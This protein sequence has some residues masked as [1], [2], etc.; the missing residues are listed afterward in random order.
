MIATFSLVIAFLLVVPPQVI[1]G[2]KIDIIHKDVKTIKKIVKQLIIKEFLFKNDIETSLQCNATLNRRT[3]SRSSLSFQLGS[4]DYFIYVD[5][6]SACSVESLS[7]QVI[8]SVQQGICS[9]EPSP[10]DTIFIVGDGVVVG[11]C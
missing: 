6:N 10:E 8:G 7:C 3:C 2:A 9:I 4:L 11:S 1:H 5:R